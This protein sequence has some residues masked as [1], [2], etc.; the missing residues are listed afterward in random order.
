MTADSIKWDRLELAMWGKVDVLTIANFPAFFGGRCITCHWYTC[1]RVGVDRW[2]C[3]TTHFCRQNS[4]VR[5]TPQCCLIVTAVCQIQSVIAVACHNESLI[6]QQ[7]G[8]QGVVWKRCPRVPATCRVTRDGKIAT[9]LDT[10]RGFSE[11]AHSVI[12]VSTDA[13]ALDF[14]DWFSAYSI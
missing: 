2:L 8:H 5:I 4:R 10:S 9:G 11:F 6:S 12:A 13:L 1:H 3:G 14:V 7:P